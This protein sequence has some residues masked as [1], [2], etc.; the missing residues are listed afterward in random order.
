MVDPHGLLNVLEPDAARVALHRCCG[1]ARWVERMLARRPFE[2]LQSLYAA[3][4]TVWADLD[5]A[6]YLEAFAAHPRIGADLAA[7]KARFATTAA[8]SQ[9][10]QAAVAAADAGTLEA[11]R[12]ANV[13]YADRFGFI[14]IVCATGKSAQEMLSLLQARLHNEPDAEL[15]VAAAEQAKITR[16]R[17]EKLAR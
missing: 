16:L 4:E 17:L 8:W 3:A 5:R 10:E 11:L 2:S 7:L 14:F 15:R 9:A 1:S 6:D 12:A 13:A